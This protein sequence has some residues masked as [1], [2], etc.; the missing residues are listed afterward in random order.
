[1]TSGPGRELLIELAY[2]AAT[3]LFI[4]SPGGVSVRLDGG[5]TTSGATTGFVS[6]VIGTG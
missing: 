2:L 5:T 3:A 4:R 1:M 6:L